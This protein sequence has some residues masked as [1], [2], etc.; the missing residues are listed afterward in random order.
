[1]DFARRGQKS[2]GSRLTSIAGYSDR[3]RSSMMIARCGGRY[4]CI[5]ICTDAEPNDKLRDD[6]QGITR[7]KIY[8]ACVAWCAVDAIE[9][10]RERFQ[11]GNGN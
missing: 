5:T 9:G 10:G 11:A 3:E 7:E 6:K 1:M 4:G 2:K 8:R